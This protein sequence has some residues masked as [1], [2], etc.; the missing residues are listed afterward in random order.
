M[1]SQIPV[2]REGD[3]IYHA[4]SCNPLV[5]AAKTGKVRLCSIGRGSY[6]GRRLSDSELPKVKSLAYWDA[7]ELQDWGLG[8]HRNEGIELTFLESGSLDFGIIAKS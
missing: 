2:Y 4:D 5:W 3:E 8:W 6:P 1:G 7:H